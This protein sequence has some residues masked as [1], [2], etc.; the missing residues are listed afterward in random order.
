MDDVPVFLGERRELRHRKQLEHLLGR[1]AEL[2]AE[3]GYDDGPVDQDGV[4][5]MA[6]SN[7][8]SESHGLD[9]RVANQRQRVARGAAGRLWKIVTLIGCFRLGVLTG[10]G[11]RLVPPLTTRTTRSITG[12]SISTPTT[13]AKAARAGS[14]FQARAFALGRV[15]D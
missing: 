1:P 4:R 10:A 12:T 14:P 11:S 5:S 6:S 7:C 13:V 2:G 3:V 9:A 8:S 15:R